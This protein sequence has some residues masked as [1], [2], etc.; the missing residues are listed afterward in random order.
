M[1]PRIRGNRWRRATGYGSKQLPLMGAYQRE[2]VKL[3]SI[4]YRFKAF[5]RLHEK[6]KHIPDG[7]EVSF[8]VLDWFGC[9]D[10]LAGSIRR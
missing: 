8:D 5:R 4:D 9:W 2:N 3:L 1:T 10:N 7:T 6:S